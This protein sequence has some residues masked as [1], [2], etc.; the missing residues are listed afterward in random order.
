MR[1]FAMDGDI[2]A[3]KMIKEFPG[4][5][6][7][8]YVLPGTGMTERVFSKTEI[9]ADYQ[10]GFK[11]GYIEKTSGYQKWNNQSYKRNYWIVYLQKK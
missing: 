10:T 2:N 6:P 7:N 11:I 5:E 3:K 1:T 8:S 4:S 9:E